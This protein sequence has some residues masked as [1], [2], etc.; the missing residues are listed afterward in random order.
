MTTA[1]LSILS[2]V[3]APAAKTS[4]ASDN[5][6]KSGKTDAV[7]FAATLGKVDQ[8]GGK[9]AAQPAQDSKAT[10]ATTPPADDEPQAPV[11]NSPAPATN[12]DVAQIESNPVKVDAG[13]VNTQQPTPVSLTDEIAGQKPTQ[14]VKDR[15]DVDPA[16]EAA[17]PL[18]VL[19][20]PEIKPEIVVVAPP[21]QAQPQP[22]ENAAESIPESA[23]GSSIL[24][25]ISMG[26]SLDKPAVDAQKAAP[27]VA[28][29]LTAVLPVTVE[30]ESAP[31]TEVDPKTLE[32]LANELAGKTPSVASDTKA[33]PAPAPVADIAMPQSKV[34]AEKVIDVKAADSALRIDGVANAN[35][36]VSTAQSTVASTATSQG[37][38]LQTP[39]NS[40]DWAKNLGQQLVSFHLKG[41]QNVQ[42][43]LNP[44][45]L[46]PMS[47]TLNVNEHL[48][49]TAHFSS[50]SGQVRSALEQG[51]AQLR[52]SMAQQGISLGE[53]SVGEQRQQGFGQSETGQ[54]QRT[55]APQLANLNLVADDSTTVSAAKTHTS[56][57]ISTYA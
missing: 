15:D 28:A 35:P 54:S 20:T 53:T 41:E 21:V 40:P 37:V 46:G 11:K 12:V 51:I 3:L 30:S 22:Q 45:N 29:K 17:L 10:P 27:T 56:G 6:D 52:E 57:E 7:S 33:A 5:A 9:K 38:T 25:S 44:S 18:P 13:Q 50:H 2:S 43:H 24:A 36:A 31:A 14:D 39:V 32:K 42:L 49:A 1:S 48:Q 8:A 26:K 19:P 4:T 16:V 23:L 34:T 47:I 55:N